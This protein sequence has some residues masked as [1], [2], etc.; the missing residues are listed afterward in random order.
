MIQPKLKFSPP[1]Y[2]NEE[3]RSVLECIE[4]GWT[5]SGPKLAEFEKKFREYKK[6]DYSAGFFSCTS[7]LFL[8]LKVLG[9]K[10]GDEVI[11]TA[12]TFCST[13]NSIIHTGAKPVLCDID[14]LTKN[15]T[16][17]E[18]IKKISSKTKAIIPVHFAGYPCDMVAIMN[19]ARAHNLFVIEDCAHAIETEFNSK[20]CGTY[21]DI[22]CFSFYAT[23]NIAIGEGGMAISNNHNLISRMSSLAL[24]GLSKDA[25]QRYENAS[26][27]SYDVKEIGYKMNMTD[28]QSSI[29]LVQLSRIKEM[30]IK[31]RQI[32]DYYNENLKNTSISLPILPK[33]EGDKHALHLY[34]IALP[35]E[36]NRDE[37]IWKAVNNFGITF[38][39]HYNSIPTFTAYKKFFPTNKINSLYP[40]ALDWG[41]RTISLS[42]S[43]SVEFQDCQRII[44]CIK[45]FL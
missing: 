19:V 29:G 6:I 38:G 24:H 43:A 27:K 2:T 42:L 17:E 8:A 3:K 36:I 22:G 23:K 10:E 45:S 16:S 13:V 41:K 9:I 44:E 4:N 21:G 31:R 11:T 15:I 7:A 5:G 34:S 30:Q 33:S 1:S 20:H 12:M 32:W 40:N 28:I 35:E 37:F 25:W 18:I 26:K 39:V 14:A